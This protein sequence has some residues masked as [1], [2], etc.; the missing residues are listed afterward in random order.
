[1]VDLLLDGTSRQQAIDRDRLLLAN[2]PG[3][4]AGLKPI[5]VRKHW[6]RSTYHGHKG[7]TTASRALLSS[8]SFASIF[9]VLSPEAR[10]K[11]IGR[12]AAKGRKRMPEMKNR[13]ER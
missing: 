9:M 5:K 2:T 6:V 4:F 8:F 7:V 11:N 12:Y 10:E 3:A 1:M 13:G